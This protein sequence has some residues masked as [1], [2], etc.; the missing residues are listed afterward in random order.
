MLVIKE[1][2]RTFPNTNLLL[3]P[4]IQLINEEEIEEIFVVLES[5]NYSISFDV[6]SYTLITLAYS[7]HQYT[8]TNKYMHK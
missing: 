1:P 8:L 3:I 4:S 7:K 6:L 2:G 5:T